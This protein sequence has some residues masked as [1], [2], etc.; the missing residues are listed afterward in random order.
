MR[1]DGSRTQFA[2]ESF[3]SVASSADLTSDHRASRIRAGSARANTSF[4]TI[5]LPTGN[6][7]SSG[8]LKGLS[9]ARADGVKIHRHLNAMNTQ[10][11]ETNAGLA[12]EAE[13]WRDEA[14]RL[15]ELLRQAGVD[16][17]E[18][19][20]L[21]NLSAQV[22]QV[23]V[24][25]TGSAG[26]RARDSSGVYRAA[27]SNASHSERLDTRLP[28]VSD[29]LLSQ[30]QAY[31]IRRQ[32]ANSSTVSTDQLT[33]EENEAIVDEMMDRIDLLEERVDKKQHQIDTLQRRA[34]SGTR[35]RL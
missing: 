22:D 14:D 33:P 35:I 10:L 29:L 3:V 5:L 26:H 27:T 17:E 23:D 4:P 16:F 25:G 8:S 21:A 20:V 34:R 2:N 6:N 1:V 7:A 15:A 19:D 13:A 9:E 12:R 31:D 11:L 24:S 28:A 32:N 30:F 18:V